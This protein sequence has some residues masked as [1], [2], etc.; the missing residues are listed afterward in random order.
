[1]EQLKLLLDEELNYS[2]KKSRNNMKELMQVQLFALPHF[3]NDFLHLCMYILAR[4]AASMARMQPEMLKNRFKPTPITC[5]VND[6]KEKFSKAEE[7]KRMIV[8]E[9]LSVMERSSITF[10]VY[11]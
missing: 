3:C 5:S 8:H 1:M 7:G 10:D 11:M 6:I 4:Q 2:K 9:Q